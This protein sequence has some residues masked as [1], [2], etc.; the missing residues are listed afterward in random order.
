MN[1]TTDLLR[2]AYAVSRILLQ[3]RDLP[4]LLQGVCDQLAKAGLNQAALLVLMDRDSGG[5]ITA[6]TNLGERFETVMAHLRQGRL[7]ACGI[8]V[9]EADSDAAVLCT[10]CS[11]SMCGHDAAVALCA[12]LRCS[13]GL[14]GFLVVR[15]LSEMQP[16]EGEI[17]LIGELAESITQAL[18]QLFAIEAARH[19]EQ[20]LQRSEERYELALHASQAGLWDWNIKTGEMYTSP[21][22]WEL[23]DYRADAEHVDGQTRFIHPD[24]RE[25][26]LAVLN[27]HLTGK[28]PEYRIEYRV[29]EKDGGWAWFLD[30]GRVVER[31]ENGMPVRMTGTHQNITLQKRQDHALGL[32]ERQ[33]HEA[34]DYERNFLQTVID[35]AGDPVMAIDLDFNLLLINRAAAS[36]VRG[37][38]EVASMQGQKCYQLF[39]GASEPCRDS[40]FPCPVVEINSAHRQM[41]LIHNPYHGN[42]V[43]NTF[44]LDVSPLRDGRGAL[45]GI[46]EVARDITDRLRIEKDLRDSQ[47]HLYRLAHH[48]ILTGLPNRLLFQ[49]RLAQALSKA[50][51]NRTGVA[52]LFLDLDRF[53]IIND[54]LGHDV[55]DGLL[56]EVAARLQRQCRQSDTVAR[57]GGDEFVFVLEAI[58]RRHDAAVVAAKIMNA[59]AEPVVVDHHELMIST[60]IGIALYPDDAGDGEELLKCADMALY[61]AK[62]TGRNTFEFYRQDLPCNGQR[63]QL[64][65]EPFQAA[66]AENQFTFQFLPQYELHHDRLVGFNSQLLWR[67]PDMGVL[68]PDAFIADADACGMLGALSAWIF[69]EICRSLHSWRQ[70]SGRILPVTVPVASR[71]LLED[72][73]PL[74]VTEAA[75]RFDIS[76]EMLVLEVRER[77]LA[78]GTRLDL[79]RLAAVARH[80]FVLGL[81]DFGMA[82]CPLA[83][84]QQLPLQR[85]RLT[86]SLLVEGEAEVKVATLVTA[87]VNLCHG[88]G[89]TVLADGVE[90]QAQLEMLRR[91][92]CD[93]A[94]GP[95]LAPPLDGNKVG[96]L[97]LTS[98]KGR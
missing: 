94:Q 6:E 10:D 43:N 84:L 1:R 8:Q 20:E 2:A 14:T 53:K 55:G 87:L 21:D 54:T 51:R 33:L 4:T 48:D 34:V 22:H 80:G 7:P 18:R 96:Q 82:G 77:A 3:E 79:E 73:F 23:L 36:L 41:K 50:D 69:T 31:D 40:R 56:V 88:L 64:I 37:G 5:M 85:I 15:L 98:E 66:L 75:K 19:R 52:V 46:I 83:R 71:Q 61:A 91:C 47:S 11:C 97:L 13:P 89:L 27:E 72:D 39:H 35:S 62:E 38:G 32:V 16:D 30:R 29:S 17:A 9:L 49:D 78:T 76:P 12:P 95:L 25:R 86:R 42:A 81:S 45:Y 67:H 63:P 74:M 92:G 93:F 44:E 60:S 65:A 24:D 26:V 68:L 58:G 28:T 57:L 70:A 59:M 90:E